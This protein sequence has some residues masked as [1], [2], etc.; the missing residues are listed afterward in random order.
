MLAGV[1]RTSWKSFLLMLEP[2]IF[3][4]PS[5]YDCHVFTRCFWKSNRLKI[6]EMLNT[7]LYVPYKFN[8]PHL[9]NHIEWILKKHQNTYDLSVWPPR[10]FSVTILIF[11]YSITIFI[12]LTVTWTS[13][14]QRILRHSHQ[15]VF[16]TY[17]TIEGLSGWTW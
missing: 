9:L 13:L 16:D 17:V 14:V 6:F 4:H 15:T 3:K 2:V 11:Y 8:L 10:Q 5:I 1:N 7:A 12:Q